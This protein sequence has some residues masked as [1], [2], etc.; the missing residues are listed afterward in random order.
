MLLSLYIERVASQEVS[1]RMG[2]RAYTE[3]TIMHRHNVANIPC[4]RLPINDKL[5][6]TIG[7]Q[8]TWSWRLRHVVRCIDDSN[9]K[10][11]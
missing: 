6:V 10:I 5:H 1:F 2:I 11:T 4:V 7:A 8:A 3:A 9:T